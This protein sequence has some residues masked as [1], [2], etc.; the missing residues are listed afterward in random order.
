[1]YGK[2]QIDVYV[3]EYVLG[4]DI[5]ALL[6]PMNMAYECRFSKMN[7]IMSDYHTVTEC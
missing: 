7:I 3:F 4:V 5:D 2:Q 1:M 6:L